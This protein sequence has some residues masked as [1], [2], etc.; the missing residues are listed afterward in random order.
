MDIQ[1][2]LYSRSKDV[3]GHMEKV[4]VE[5][6]DFYIYKVDG[7][8]D[9]YIAVD[10]ESGLQN[11]VELVHRETD[12]SLTEAELFTKCKDYDYSGEELNGTDYLFFRLKNKGGI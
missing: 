7:P 5:Y 1:E 9:R 11:E 3:G 10:C 4:I 2:I 6:E 8:T 12:P